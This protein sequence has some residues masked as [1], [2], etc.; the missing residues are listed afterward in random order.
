MVPGPESNNNRELPI[1]IRTEHELLF[2]DGTQVPEP[3]IVTFIPVFC[4]FISDLID[5]L[6]W[7]VE[8]VTSRARL[9]KERGLILFFNRQTG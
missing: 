6:G 2:S 7:P 3:N 5:S 8:P 1:C 9:D 4:A